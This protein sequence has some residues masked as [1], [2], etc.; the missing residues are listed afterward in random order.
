M[1]SNFKEIDHRMYYV[2][3]TN[4]MVLNMPT[5]IYTA[6]QSLRK[7]TVVPIINWKVPKPHISYYYEFM[8]RAAAVYNLHKAEMEVFILWD[9]INKSHVFYIPTQEVSSGNVFF[10]WEIPENHVLLFEL[11]SHHTMSITFSATDD[12]NDSSVDILPHISAVLKKIDSVNMLDLNKNVDIRLSYLGNRIPLSI[13]DLFI[14]EEFNMPQI[15]K[16]VAPVVE[17]SKYGPYSVGNYSRTYNYVPPIKYEKAK[18]ETSIYN[19]VHRK[20]TT[21]TKTSAFDK[22]EDASDVLDFVN[23]QLETYPKKVITKK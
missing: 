9:T 22:L 23:K 16:Y 17:V 7:K 14:E 4:T 20:N 13:S 8:K 3:E 2:V 6:P 18:K 12:K 10:S 19:S 21:N 5:D 1:S 15:T 11:H